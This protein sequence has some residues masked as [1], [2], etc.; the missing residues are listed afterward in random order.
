MKI[1]LIDKK[2]KD[3]K[4]DFEI[5]FLTNKNLKHKWVK[6]F[7]LF[8]ELDFKGEDEEK[9]CLPEKKRIYIGLEN[10]EHENIRVASASAIRQVLKLKIKNVKIG[11]YFEKNEREGIKAIAEGVLLGAYSFQKYKTKKKKINVKE[12][13]ISSENYHS[14]KVNIKGLKK[15]LEE[16]MIISENVNF[17]REIVN[18]A[19]SILNPL[20]FS[21]IARQRAKKNNLQI[22]ILAKK[23]LE[24]LGMNAFLAVNRASIYPPQLI[25][26]VYKPKKTKKKIVLV[27]KGLTYDTGGLSLKLGEGMLTMKMDMGGAGAVLG[28]ILTASQL[29]L[30]LEIHAILGV[31]ENAI[32]QD[33]Y[34]P[35][36]ILKAMN[37]KTI[38][39]RNTD[40][41]G[42]LVLAD[43]LVYAQKEKP[44]F[45]LD[46]ATLTGASLVA[47]GEYTSAV[48]GYDK[49]LKEDIIISSEKS[50]EL[51]DILPF[52]KYLSKLLKSH[53]ADISNISSSKYGGAITAGLFLGEF[54]E[55]KNKNKWVHLDIAGPAY[56]EKTWGENPYGASGVGVRT[57]IEFLKSI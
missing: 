43:C 12:V 26:I 38:E 52:N 6:D 11:L 16:A 46:L 19:P 31:T 24:K 45:I 53:I 49:K 28:T 51:M 27:G 41:E 34:K 36:D 32:G 9:L 22:K 2:L 21:K 10:L 55:E 48:M 7:S 17:V 4:A 8:S 5:I 39:V 13:Y 20:E 33:A 29:K 3:I 14:K 42:R 47:L 23:E 54:I 25:H 30:D 35:D 40:A 57:L 56:K 18:E 37:G 50:G 15:S 1:K 44:D